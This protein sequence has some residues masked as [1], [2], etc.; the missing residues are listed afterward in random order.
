[1]MLVLCLD[2]LIAEKTEEQKVEWLWKDIHGSE[3]G[4]QVFQCQRGPHPHR[5]SCGAGCLASKCLTTE[6]KAPLYLGFFGFWSNVWDYLIPNHFLGDL[7][8]CQLSVGLRQDKTSRVAQAGGAAVVHGVFAATAV[9]AVGDSFWSPFSLSL[10]AR[11]EPF[12]D[13]QSMMKTSP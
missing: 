4:K 7:K 6:K 9:L 5:C 11:N 13:S 10:Q 12:L 2:A 1:M 8:R 3:E